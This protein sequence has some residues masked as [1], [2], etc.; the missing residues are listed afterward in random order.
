M[1]SEYEIISL[2]Q[3]CL[4]KLYCTRNFLKKTKK[5]GELTLPFDLAGHSLASIINCIETDFE[6][7]F[8]GLTYSETETTFYWVN[9]KYRNQYNHDKDCGKN[10][11]GKF[12]ERY[13]NRIENFKKLSN[14]DKFIFYIFASYSSEPSEINRLYG[15]LK[16][17]RQN[18][19]FKLIVADMDLTLDSQLEEGITIFSPK[20]PFSELKDWNAWENKSDKTEQVETDFTSFVKNEISKKFKVILYKPKLIDYENKFMYQA[21]K[22]IQSIFSVTNGNGP[23]KVI[24]ILGIRIK[25]KKYIKQMILKKRA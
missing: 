21:R 19:P 22:I 1:N 7:F 4:P 3:N 16:K 23:H 5:M 17:C 2:G 15:A 6:G 13:T 20:Y 8:D 24:T 25:V 11:L 9:K 10:D 14:D 12:V 18:K